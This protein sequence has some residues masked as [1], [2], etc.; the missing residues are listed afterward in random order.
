MYLF[1]EDSVTSIIESSI[2]TDYMKLE[3]LKK[4]SPLVKGS[5]DRKLLEDKI[6][7][8]KST[9]NSLSANIKLVEQEFAGCNIKVQY[10][11]NN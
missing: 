2:H 7:K 1:E 4:N 3:L 5:R 10:L 8:I 9:S 11:I 6:S